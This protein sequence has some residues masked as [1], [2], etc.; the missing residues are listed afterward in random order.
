MAGEDYKQIITELVQKQMVVLG[1]NIALDKA[2]QVAGLSLSDEGA[3]LD[4]TGDPK[5]VLKALAEEYIALSGPVAKMTLAS[6]MEK[7]PSLKGL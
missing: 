1:P 5:M 2:R 3:V 6:L 7:Y 4:I